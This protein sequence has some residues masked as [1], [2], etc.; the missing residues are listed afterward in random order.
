MG[1]PEAIII[2][3]TS[4]FAIGT[5]LTALLLTLVL[6]SGGDGRG[7]RFLFAICILIA[8]CAG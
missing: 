4:G 8:N 2:A 6:R 5:A 7:A 1:Y 3:Q